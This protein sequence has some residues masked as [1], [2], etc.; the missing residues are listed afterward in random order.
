MN[1]AAQSPVD[2][3]RLAAWM[4]NVPPWAKGLPLAAA[5]FETYRYRKD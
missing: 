4:A 3:D 1:A 5:G 2:S